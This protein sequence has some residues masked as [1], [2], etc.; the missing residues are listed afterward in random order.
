[1][2]RDCV[3]P[4]CGCG[5]FHVLQETVLDAA[6][7]RGGLGLNMHAWQWEIRMA[8][9]QPQAQAS[10][11]I[12]VTAADPE[13]RLSGGAYFAAM[14]ELRVWEEAQRPSRTWREPPSVFFF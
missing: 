3:N 8:A 4:L 10:V 2:E 1:M 5:I 11:R 12:T 14:A 7:A 6:P 13:V 9:V